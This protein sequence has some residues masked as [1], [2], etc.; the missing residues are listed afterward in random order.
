MR[1]NS[2]DLN[3][4]HQLK[5]DLM[6][7]NRA[8]ILQSFNKLLDIMD[9]LRIKCPWDK[10]QTIDSLRTLTIEETYELADAILEKDLPGICEELGDI[11]LHI[12]F[13]ARIG[14]ENDAFTMKEVIDGINKKLVF[15]H[16]HIFG[17]VIVG[18]AREVEQNW[19]KIK[20]TEHLGKTVLGGIPAS[21]PAM[22]KAY[23]IQDKARGVGFDWD[24]REQVWDKVKEEIGELMEEV[25]NHQ[26]DDRIEAE[27]GDVLFSLINAARLYQINPENAL[28]R[29]NLKFIHRFNYL[30]KETSKK[31]LNL[32][33][34][35]V[36]EMNQYW[37][38]AKL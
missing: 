23:R 27:F 9:E 12:V 6:N 26:S 22:I 33:N 18:N 36:D 35:T 21:L 32:K 15:R 38:E 5:S 30:E 31:G 20:L 29:T 24:H 1:Q 28:E 37:N 4:E 17:D 3:P 13:Y 8:G 25:E 19:E 11:L 34:M 7:S 16:P 2:L 14:Q 10:E